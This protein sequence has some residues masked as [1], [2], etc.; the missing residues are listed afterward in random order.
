VS[1]SN[2]L[3]H[4]DEASLSI[5]GQAGPDSETCSVARSFDGGGPLTK[6][7]GSLNQLLRVQ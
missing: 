4:L 3:V 2:S 1:L 7:A 5:P 6:I